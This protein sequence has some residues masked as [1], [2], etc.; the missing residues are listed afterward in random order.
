MFW[1]PD[2]DVAFTSSIHETNLHYGNIFFNEALAV[3]SAIEWAAYLQEWPQQIL[4]QTDSM[5]T[6]DMFN[7][8]APETDLIP[9][10]FRA[11]EIMMNSG[12]DVRVVHIPGVDNIVADALSCSLFDMAHKI[13][14]G[15]KISTFKPP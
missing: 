7:T 12:V 14:S 5:N 10:M 6:V 2:L 3:L 11:I 8:M 15:L 1:T 9:L 13:R 4:I